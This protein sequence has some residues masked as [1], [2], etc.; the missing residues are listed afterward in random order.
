MLL[1]TS[2]FGVTCRS[3]SQTLRQTGGA[4]APERFRCAPALARFA[5]GAD[6]YYRAFLARGIAANIRD[7]TGMR[8]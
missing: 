3:R 2:A 4:G 8:G 1:L 6:G 7:G 5:A